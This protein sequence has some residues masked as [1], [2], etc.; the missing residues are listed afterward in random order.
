MTIRFPMDH[1]TINDRVDAVNAG[2]NTL[3][4]QVE[5]SLANA[6]TGSLDL[7][8]T[9]DVFVNQIGALVIR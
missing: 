5:N 4:V 8:G 3:L 7:F 1:P 9:V 6:V 2:I